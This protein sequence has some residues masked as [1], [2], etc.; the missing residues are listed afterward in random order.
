MPANDAVRKRSLVYKDIERRLK[1]VRD[2]Y[3]GTDAMQRAGRRWLPQEPAESDELYLTRVVRSVLFNG[4]KRTVK[5]LAGKPFSKAVQLDTTVPSDIRKWCDDVDR[6]G[7]DVTM[8]ARDLLED[9]LQAGMSHFLVDYPVAPRNP[10]G[11]LIQVSAAGER[12]LGLRPYFVHIPAE[13][14]LGYRYERTNGVNVLTQVRIL[15]TLVEYDGDD[16]FAEHEVEQV[17]VIYPD[18]WE[19]YRCNEDGDWVQVDAGPNTLGFIPLVTFYTARTGFMQAD[20]P[21]EDLAWLNLQHWRSSSDQENILH[22]ARVPILFGKGMAPPPGREDMAPRLPGPGTMIQAQ[23]RVL[24]ADGRQVLTNPAAGSNG[25]PAMEVGPNRLIR[26]PENSDLKYVEHTGAAIG[27]GRQSISD[28]E[29]R[30]AVMGTEL[31]V[32]RATTQRTATETVV[33]TQT[34]VSELHVYVANLKGAL[35]QGLD[36]MWQWT[37]RKRDPAAGA[38]AAAAAA[39]MATVAGV[40]AAAAETQNR[41]GTVTINTDFGIRQR[42]ATELQTL[43]QARLAGEM[44]R[45][46]FLAE[47]QRRG[48]LSEGLRVE[49][50]ISKLEAEA[51]PAAPPPQAVALV[52]NSGAQGLG[53]GTGGTAPAAPS[54][55]SLDQRT[56]GNA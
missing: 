4:Y 16:G 49:D 25:R 5:S 33:D 55:P 52:R 15:E 43:L 30:M 19:I 38:A 53:R 36:L 12:S 42:D 31:L 6:Q 40:A 44:T 56:A 20:L 34:E 14:L 27:A 48:V 28:I 10:D 26:G 7:R 39:A 37:Q 8:F 41:G 13:N 24:A 54:N 11:S 23:G 47:L 32:Q 9:G 18:R 46:T 35:E 1:L 51:P 2:L 3:R 50:E 21:L 17:R 29:D 45:E 22:V